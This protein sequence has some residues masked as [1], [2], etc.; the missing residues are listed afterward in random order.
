MDTLAPEMTLGMQN[1]ECWWWNPSRSTHPITHEGIESSG[2]LTPSEGMRWLLHREPR[3]VQSLAKPLT[4]S[5]N[6]DALYPRQELLQA[7]VDLHQR[8]VNT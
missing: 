8:G 7:A 4:L 5:G 6:I 1:H 3:R 2:M